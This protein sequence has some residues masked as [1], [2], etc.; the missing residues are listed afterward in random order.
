MW[1]RIA[2]AGIQRD[3]IMKI[4]QVFL[5]HLGAYGFKD[6]RLIV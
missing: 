6:T 2:A 4:H 5:F 3:G 1:Q